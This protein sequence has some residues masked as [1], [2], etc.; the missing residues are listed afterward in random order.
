MATRASSLLATRRG[1]LT[2]L[3]PGYS[4][5][6]ADRRPRPRGETLTAG[7]HQALLACAIFLLA[8]AGIALH[9]TSTHGEPA[10]QPGRQPASHDPVPAAEQAGQARPHQHIRTRRHSLNDRGHPGR[11]ELPR[12]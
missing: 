5:R 4:R 3:R 7:F 11:P 1:R 12:P 10:A 9:A 8:A 2:L 6:R